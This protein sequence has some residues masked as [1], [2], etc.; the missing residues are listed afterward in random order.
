MNWCFFAHLKLEYTFGL[1]YSQAYTGRF[2]SS[3]ARA[4]NRPSL[5]VSVAA[6]ALGLLNIYMYNTRSSGS[7]CERNQ[8]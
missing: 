1:W 8:S 7:I 5:A 2:F 3:I 6:A 4:K